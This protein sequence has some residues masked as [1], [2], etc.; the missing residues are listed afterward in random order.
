MPA[1]G[2]QKLKVDSL[3]RMYAVLINTD[4]KTTEGED[5]VVAQTFS[6]RLWL[7]QHVFELS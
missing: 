4:T 1:D 2:H 3:S 5:K 7:S 6:Q